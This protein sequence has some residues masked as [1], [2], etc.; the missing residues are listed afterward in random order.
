MVHRTVVVK[1]ET[2]WQDGWSH[3]AIQL[4]SLV[5]T[6]SR[7]PHPTMSM[8]VLIFCCRSFQAARRLA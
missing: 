7:H 5:I 1:A 3:V 4:T 2:D 8:E 6:V